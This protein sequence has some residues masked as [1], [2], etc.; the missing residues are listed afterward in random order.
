MQNENDQT[1]EKCTWI[2]EYKPDYC[3]V[4][5]L[6]VY[7]LSIDHRTLM[8]LV[9]EVRLLDLGTSCIPSWRERLMSWSDLDE[10]VYAIAIAGKTG[11]ISPY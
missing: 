1:D 4:R 10:L 2:H 9:G 6:I 3:F 5:L 7:P 11:S 8:E